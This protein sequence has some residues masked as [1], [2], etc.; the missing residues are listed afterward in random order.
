MTNDDETRTGEAATR[1][2]NEA[3]AVAKT[4]VA[5]AGEFKMSLGVQIDDAGPCKKHVR[6]TIPRSD[7]AHFYDQAVGELCTSANVPGFRVGHVPKQLIERRFRSELTDQ[8]KQNILVES[9]EQVAD[10]HD[11][12]PINQPNIDIDDIDMPDEGDFEYEFEVEVRPDFELPD[13][14]RLKIKRQVREIANDDVENYLARFLSQYG[15]LVPH[16]EPAEPGDHVI[17]SAEFQHDGGALSKISELS[18]QLKPILRFQDTELPG[19]DEFMTGATSGEVREAELTISLEAEEIEMRGEKV[20]GCFT[21]LDVKRQ[22]LPELNGEF[23]ERVGV[24]SEADLRD[25]VRSILERQ[26]LFDQRQATRQQVLEK[27]TESATWDLPEQL[28]VRQVE[29]ARRR[30]ILEMQQAGFTTQEIQARENEIRQRSIST[31]RQALKEHFLLDKI[32]TKENIEV[33]PHDVRTEIEMMAM[34]SGESPRRVRAR[35]DKSGMI[36]NLQAQIRERKAV[37]F[38]LERADFE[39]VDTPPPEEDR[40]EA[41][42]QSVCGITT[43]TSSAEADESAE[44]A[45]DQGDDE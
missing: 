36:D 8:V 19:F 38:I 6:V 24:E 30:E 5:E 43:G 2:E 21:V 45:A 35:L 23:F 34:Q 7:I 14:N 31:T 42:A 4:A 41:V 17:L 12:D 11:L 9:M 32:A 40:I 3:G 18:V 37:D 16:D 1:T 39:D 33:S 28:V 22:R 26:Q 27:I 20:H 10:E 13:Y 29:N 44:T 15:Q 25:N